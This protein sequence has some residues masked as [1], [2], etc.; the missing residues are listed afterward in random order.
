MNLTKKWHS[1]FLARP[2]EEPLHDVYV[3]LIASIV[4]ALFKQYIKHFSYQDFLKILISHH[5]TKPMIHLRLLLIKEI[6]SKLLDCLQYRLNKAV[7]Q[8]LV[9]VWQDTSFLFMLYFM[10]TKF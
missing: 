6:S 8:N 1:G 3:C 5:L 7:H 4:K 2:L 10:V 9:T